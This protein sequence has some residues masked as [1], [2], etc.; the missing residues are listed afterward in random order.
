MWIRNTA[1]NHGNVFVDCS[2]R[3]T[4]GAQTVLARLPDNKGRNYPHAEVVLIDAT[5]SGIKAEGWGPIDADASQLRLWEAGSRGADGGPVDT[6]RRHPASRQLDGRKDAA[7]IARYRDPAFVL[8]GWQPA[9]A[10]II[11]RQPA[12]GATLEVT[13]AAV[14]DPAY[15]W[16]RDGKPIAGATGPRLR[17][18]GAGSYAVRVSN[19]SGTATSDAVQIKR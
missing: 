19:A 3:T 5:L 7:L 4:N 12:A 11:L 17:A 1:A 16:L 18:P 13:A 14:P 15:Q 2:F 9:L 8:G 6:S 10:P